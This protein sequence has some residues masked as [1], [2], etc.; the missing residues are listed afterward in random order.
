M[1]VNTDDM[2]YVDDMDD[3]DEDDEIR[4]KFC[5]TMS[6]KNQYEMFIFFKFR[7]K[8]GLFQ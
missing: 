7:L 8:I 3:T 4:M 1:D 6:V 2:E 5:G